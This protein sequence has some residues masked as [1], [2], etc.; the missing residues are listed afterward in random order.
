MR[1]YERFRFG[2]VDTTVL[3]LRYPFCPNPRSRSVFVEKVFFS[4]KG[5]SAEVIHTLFQKL[6]AIKS[7][8]A[9][10]KGIVIVQEIIDDFDS[11]AYAGWLASRYN[12]ITDTG[13]QEARGQSATRLTMLTK[14]QAQL[15]ELIDPIQKKSL[16]A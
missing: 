16:V 7:P 11:A 2:R 12:I 8:H 10:G 1:R 6:S 9:V 4:A 13:L 3:I 15:R 5:F 14:D